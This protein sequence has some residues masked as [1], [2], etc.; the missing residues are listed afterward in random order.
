MPI[1]LKSSSDIERMRSASI[2]V[3]DVHAHL[4]RLVQPGVTTGE[5]DS[6]AYDLIVSAGGHP[7]FLGYQ[8]YPASICASVNEIVLHG[9]PGDRT[10]LAGDIISIDLG[11]ELDGFH[12]DAAVTYAVG[13]VSEEARR[14]IDITEKCFWAGFAELRDG[15]RLGDVAAAVQACAEAASFSVIR[16]YTGHGIGRRMHEEP[17]VHNYGVRGTG[18]RLRSGM[19]LALEPMVC[20]GAPE[21]RVLDDGWT[22]VTADGSLSAHF[23]HT[24]AI[25][26]HGAL[27]L[28]SRQDR[29]I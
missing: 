19:T 10:L 3:A 27:V 28:S 16:D 5:L 22:V 26:D 23:E 17:T 2:V 6:I 4:A 9:I 24:V 11:V 29:V 18:T 21:T 25:V 15:G 12:G 7:S 8:G 14:I 1:V 20:A 13:A